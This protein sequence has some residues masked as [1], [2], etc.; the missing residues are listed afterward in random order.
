MTDQKIIDIYNI[1]YLKPM[2]K[3]DLAAKLDT[4]TKTIENKVKLTNEDIIYDK[5]ISC[6]RFANLI[7]KYIS[8][9][10]LIEISIEGICNSVLLEESKNI[11]GKSPCNIDKTL[12]GT[13]ELPSL[14]KTI[15]KLQLAINHGCIVS[16]DYTSYKATEKKIIQPNKVF[17]SNG[18]Y[19]LS[20]R[21][22]ENNS[23]NIGERRVFAVNAI[24]NI[25]P[26]QFAGIVDFESKDRF[27]AFGAF[28]DKQQYI[29]LLFTGKAAKHFE[30]EALRG[31]KY[32][33]MGLNNGYPMLKIYYKSDKD[34][35]LLEIITLIQFW[36]PFVKILDDNSVSEKILST[37]G[38]NCKL[39]RSLDDLSS[40]VDK[41]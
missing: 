14:L 7:P 15:L 3:N 10:N 28:G 41:V 11:F 23:T 32:D 9:K 21:Y 1:L 4:T 2:S 5:K 22:D 20:L 30:R 26:L 33:Y 37:I 31:Y 8:L 27:N 6:Y 29:T 39:L 12:V 36:M 16:V 38:R 35:D 17:I 40:N 25:E 13:E 34:E 18:M 19:Y 24:K